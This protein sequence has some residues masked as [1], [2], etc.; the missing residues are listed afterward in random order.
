M[1]NSTGFGF[2]QLVFDL[3]QRSDIISQNPG[4]IFPV[5]HADLFPHLR[6]RRCDPGDVL[7]SAR[8][9]QLHDAVFGIFVLDQVDKGRSNNMWQMADT[10][11]HI[12]MS[13]I[14]DDQR[15]CF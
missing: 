8:G 7:E 5:G 11:S 12:I 6:G 15:K 1:V 14:V 3:L 4:N 9:D 10:C 13:V 2:I